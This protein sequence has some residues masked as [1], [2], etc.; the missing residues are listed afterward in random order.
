LI[1]SRDA[2]K[3]GVID[4]MVRKAETDGFMVPIS[5]EERR[6]SLWA[7]LAAHEPGAPVWVFGYGSL[8]WNP[9][10]HYAE[11]RSGLVHG[12]HRSYCMWSPGGRGTPEKPGLMLALDHGGS[13]RGMAFRIA[14]EKVEE[15][16]EIVWSREMIGHAY[17]ARWVRVR[18]GGEIVR[19]VAFVIDRGYVRYAGKVPRDL[20][21]AHLATAAGRLG[22]SMEYLENTVAHLDELG[23]GDGPM[24]DMLQRARAYRGGPPE[25]RWEKGRWRTKQGKS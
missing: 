22:S 5:P 8:M 17:R 19:A 12:Y 10:F 23:I 16:L 1:L 20:Q 11:K 7:M 21:A 13:C 3:R 15:E 6:E 24:H 9:A 25:G 2:I 18:T 14:P 4:E